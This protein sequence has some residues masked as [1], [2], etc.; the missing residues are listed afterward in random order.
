M[1]ADSLVDMEMVHLA[2][3]LEK[4]VEV[5]N[6]PED[7]LVGNPLLVGLVVDNHLLVVLV[8]DIRF[9]GDLEGN[10]LAD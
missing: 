2:Y 7:N 9:Q 6:Y 1:S 10:N 3:N 4:M 8:E 5:D